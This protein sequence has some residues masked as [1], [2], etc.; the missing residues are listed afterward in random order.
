MGQ[1]FVFKVKRAR[2]FFKRT[3]GPKSFCL[4]KKG[5]LR[6][7]LLFQNPQ[8]PPCVPHK[9][10]SV[11]SAALSLED[12]IA[13]SGILTLLKKQVFSFNNNVL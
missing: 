7:F 11:P 12:R 6:L 8:N 10:W 1:G 4:E 2:T 5:G 9:F 13:K 3:R